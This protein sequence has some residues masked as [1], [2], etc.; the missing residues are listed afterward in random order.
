MLTSAKNWS[1]F[2]VLMGYASTQMEVMSV[3][4]PKDKNQTRTINVVKVSDVAK[5]CRTVSSQFFIPPANIST[6]F[7]FFWYFVIDLQNE[8]TQAVFPFVW[9]SLWKQCA[10]LKER[11]SSRKWHYWVLSNWPLW[12]NSV[13]PFLR[14][15]PA[16]LAKVLTDE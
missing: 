1:S 10:Q 3:S 12:I 6:F 14:G 2:V 16:N 8:T 9:I 13:F 5:G 4:A 11:D 7:P 15:T